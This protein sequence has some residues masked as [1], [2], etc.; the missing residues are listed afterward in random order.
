MNSRVAVIIPAYNHERYVGEALESVLA[1]S[2]PAERVLVVDD[3]STDRTPRVLRRFGTRGVE[4]VRQPNAGTHAALNR[5]VAAV[6]DCEVV[7][8][9]NSD[10]R[11][12][13]ERRKL[14]P[15]FGRQILAK[16]GDILTDDL[17]IAGPKREL[18]GPRT[19]NACRPGSR[20]LR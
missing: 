4:V 3:G 8:I 19:Q 6:R 7:A 12:H 17:L 5:A 16:V 10:D 20:R 15:S 2:R 13:Q 9:L 18:I 1:Q 14:V 11:F